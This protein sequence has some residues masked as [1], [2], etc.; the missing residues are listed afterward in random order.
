MGL[1]GYYKR[2]ITGFS[3]IVHPITSLQN[4]GNKFEWTSECEE[5]FNLLELLISAPLLNIVDPNENF[6]V[7]ADTCK[8]RLGGFLTQNGHVIS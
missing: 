7:C 8:E 1:T 6:V 2:S 5:N 4:K 3:K